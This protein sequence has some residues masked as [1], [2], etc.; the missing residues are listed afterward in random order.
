MRSRKQI[1]KRKKVKPVDK[2]Q[3]YP[4]FNP[5][6]PVVL[7]PLPPG[8][9]QRGIVYPGMSLRDYCSIEILKAIA[10]VPVTTVQKEVAMQMRIET[11]FALAD[12]WCNH[13]E[14]EYNNAVR[15]SEKLE[16]G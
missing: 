16:R 5:A 4:G 1:L 14:I 13:R 6:F 10:A 8:S 2:L 15:M 11:C 12:A 7:P 9:I 3:F